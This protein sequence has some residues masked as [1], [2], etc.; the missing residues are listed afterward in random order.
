M[1]WQIVQYSYVAAD[2]VRKQVARNGAVVHIYCAF[3]LLV[4]CE[5][6]SLIVMLLHGNAT[7]IVH[8]R[9]HLGIIS[10]H[11]ACTIA[12]GSRQ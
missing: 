12:I 3:V 1:P 2:A 10:G 8:F 11:S 9:S 5:C 7:V 4:S 6:E